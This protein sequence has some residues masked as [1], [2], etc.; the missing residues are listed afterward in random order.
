MSAE[1]DE[2]T[3]RI[4]QMM[5]F[6]FPGAQVDEEEAGEPPFH[7]DLHDTS[8]LELYQW[9]FAKMLPGEKV[10]D[11][12]KRV[13]KSEEPIDEVAK[14]VSELFL[15]GETKIVETDWV[16]TGINA[17]KVGELEEMKWDLEENGEVTKNRTA[18]ELAPRLRVLIAE[19]ARVRIDGTEEWI[20]IDKINFTYLVL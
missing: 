10:I 11:M 14:Y 12:M 15:R 7:E 18:A 16:W 17:G 4:R 9:V 13:D 19:D 3:E 8:R 5:P 2:G 1:K 6:L 20:P